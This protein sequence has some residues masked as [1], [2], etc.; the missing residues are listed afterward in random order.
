[1]P[2]KVM[3]RICSVPTSVMRLERVMRPANTGICAGDHDSLPFEP[4]RPDVR[5]MRVNDSRLDRRRRARSAG[6]QRRLLDRAWLRKIIVNQG[7]TLDACYLRSSSQSVGN[8]ASAFHQNGVNDIKGAMLDVAV[9]QPLQDRFLGAVRLLQQGLIN[10]SA[11]LCLGGQTSRTTQIG[12]IDEH[13]E[14]FGLLPVDSVFHNPRRDLA[15]RSESVPW[16]IGLECRW[17]WLG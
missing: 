12:L 1:M 14:K 17:P 10:E 5:R 9:A 8:L 2:V 4:E 15:R 7:I 16:C 11:L 3:V 6:L 13:N